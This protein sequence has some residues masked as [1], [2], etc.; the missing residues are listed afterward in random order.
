[1]SDKVAAV[2]VVEGK[3]QLSFYFT[4]LPMVGE[5][6]EIGDLGTFVVRRVVHGSVADTVHVAPLK[7]P[8]GRRR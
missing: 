8:R 6:V 7:P 3:K 2:V 1:M 4:R 5:E